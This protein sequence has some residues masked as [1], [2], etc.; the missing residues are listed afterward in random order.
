MYLCFHTRDVHW[1][2]HESYTCIDD[3]SDESML[4]NVH[5]P[6]V[7]DVVTAKIKQG[8]AREDNP[9]TSSLPVVF[10]NFDTLTPARPQLPMP[11]SETPLALTQRLCALMS[12]QQWRLRSAASRSANR[13]ATWSGS[14]RSSMY[15]ISPPRARARALSRLQMRQVKISS[16]RD[17]GPGAVNPSL[18]Q[19]TP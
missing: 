9:R 1:P 12:S 17:A 8:D 16:H 3:I 2:Y 11:A 10:S 13:R 18:Y 7:L 15:L 14:G 6:G 5:L 19:D 4:C